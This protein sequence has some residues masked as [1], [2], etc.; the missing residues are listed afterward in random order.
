MSLTCCLS[1]LSS[2]R[3]AT[4]IRSLSRLT[5]GFLLY[6]VGSVTASPVAAQTLLHFYGLGIEV[7]GSAVHLD[8]YKASTG[9]PVLSQTIRETGR[10]PDMQ[11]DTNG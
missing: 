5:C 6:A 2:R 9:K 8:I 10:T 4:R 7:N 3:T 11:Y 1:L